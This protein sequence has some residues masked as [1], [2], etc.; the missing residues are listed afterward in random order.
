MR[1]PVGSFRWQSGG[2][3]ILLLL[4]VR[5]PSLS[6]ALERRLASVCCTKSPNPLL[7]SPPSSAS[8][9]HCS[10]SSLQNR[11]NHF[12]KY[13]IIPIIKLSPKTCDFHVICPF[14]NALIRL[15][16]DWLTFI[17]FNCSR[18]LFDNITN[19]QQSALFLLIHFYCLASERRWI[20]KT[21]LARKFFKLSFILLK[22]GGFFLNFLTISACCSCVPICSRKYPRMAPSKLCCRST[23]PGKRPTPLTYRRPCL[24]R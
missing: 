24:E 15:I 11:E 3:D 4:E 21:N 13:L 10:L 2:M 19:L 16:V 18:R 5:P 12:G 1:R 17:N 20:Y 14:Q 6:W 7:L 22:T 8:P 23:R 9:F